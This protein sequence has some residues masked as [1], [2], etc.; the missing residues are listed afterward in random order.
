[1]FKQDDGILDKSE[2]LGI[3]VNMRGQFGFSQTACDRRGNDGRTVFVADIVLYDQNRTQ[4]SL[5]A[6]DNGAEIRII[7]ISSFDGH[8]RSLFLFSDFFSF[9]ENAE[10]F[11]AFPID[12]SQS[13]FGFNQ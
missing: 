7:N 11:S 6:S 1:L 9:G 12:F 8:F 10:G 3:Y 2:T 5:F 4:S 13:I